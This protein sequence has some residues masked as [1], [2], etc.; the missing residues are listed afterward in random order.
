MEP[1]AYA[2]LVRPFP[3]YVYIRATLLLLNTFNYVKLHTANGVF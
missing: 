2:N 1:A 3:N